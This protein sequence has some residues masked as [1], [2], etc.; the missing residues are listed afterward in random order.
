[1]NKEELL[2]LSKEEFIVWLYSFACEE[3]NGDINLALLELELQGY[4]G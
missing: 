2:R 1:M 3:F 4:L